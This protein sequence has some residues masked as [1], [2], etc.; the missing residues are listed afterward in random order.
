MDDHR[1]SHA[2]DNPHSTA[3]IGGHPIH[4][5]L[6]PFPIVCFVGALVTDLVF[7]NNGDAGWAEASR[8]LLGIGLVMA[9]LA[10][11]AGLTE[12]MGDDRIRRLGDAVKHMIANVTVVVLEIVNFVLRLK[13]DDAVGGVGVYL[14]AA[15][16]LLLLYSGWLGGQLVFIHRIGV[17]DRTRLM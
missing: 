11:V 13:N 14:S 3:Q 15:S 16:V 12:F 1:E 10:A 5:M 7:L 6:I 2:T 8:W 4:P 17:R 9:A